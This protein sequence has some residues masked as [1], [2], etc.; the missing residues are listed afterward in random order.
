V[1]TVAF[2]VFQSRIAPVFDTA[3][4]VLLLQV[5][6]QHELARSELHTK[7]LSGSERV[8]ALRRAGVTALICAGISNI[9]HTMLESADI[10]VTPG[11]VGPVEEVIGAYLSNGLDD[12]RFFMPGHGGRGVHDLE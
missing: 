7:N 11:I 9:T 10:R 12:P 1:S 3:V 6:H 2:P 4:R 8:A 5:E